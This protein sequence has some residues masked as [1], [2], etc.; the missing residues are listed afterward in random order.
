MA[1]SEFLVK[2]SFSKED[3]Y[4]YPQCLGLNVFKNKKIKNTI[5]EF[6]PGGSG[7]PK[8]GPSFFKYM[9]FGNRVQI[10]T[11]EQKGKSLKVLKL[12]NKTL[13]FGV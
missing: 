1:S 4:R 2:A 6:S 8:G 13:W 5:E 3:R 11:P 7:P 10:S 12:A 9:L